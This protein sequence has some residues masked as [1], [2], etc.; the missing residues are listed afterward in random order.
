MDKEA[1][2]ELEEAEKRGRKSRALF[3]KLDNEDYEQYE[4][5]YPIIQRSSH[6]SA[7]WG[8]PLKKRSFPTVAHNY[9]FWAD[10]IFAPKSREKGMLLIVEGTS[11]WCWCHPFFT[12]SSFQ[13]ARIIEKF[14]NFIKEKITCLTTDAG[15]EWQGIPPLTEK[16]GFVWKEEECGSHRTWSH[17]KTG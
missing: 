17:G 3:R 15:N 14:I 2:K 4:I 6:Y 11:R 9:S 12:K 16:Y 13:I 5:E 10:L 8:K 1:Y 7:A